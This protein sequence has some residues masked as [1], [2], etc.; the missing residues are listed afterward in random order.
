VQVF[1]RGQ[2][3]VADER[4]RQ[5]GF[6][7]F[8][9]RVV[10]RTVRAYIGLPDQRVVGLAEMI[11]RFGSEVRGRIEFA[12]VRRTNGC[13]ACLDRAARRRNRDLARSMLL[14]ERLACLLAEA[15]DFAG[16]VHGSLR[17]TGAPERELWRPLQRELRCATRLEV[18]DRLGA[19]TL[20]GPEVGDG[21][22]VRDE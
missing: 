3:F 20:Q 11:T 4:K 8:F 1:G 17:R 2:R 21:R 12:P 18:A 16:A 13:G 5:P 7:E 22:D 10:Q 15:S 14:L 19:L 6:R 9:L